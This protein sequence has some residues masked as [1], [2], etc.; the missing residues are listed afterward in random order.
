MQCPKCQ[1]ENPTGINFCGECGGKLERLCPGC[2]SPNPLNF[3]FC[4][5]CGHNLIPVKEISEQKSEAK[6]LKPR[7]STKKSLSM[8]VMR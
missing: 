1:F 2:N 6:N 4:G 5:E 8:P 3:K 7:P